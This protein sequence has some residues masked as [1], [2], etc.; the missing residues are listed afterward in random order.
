MRPA[1]SVGLARI[2]LIVCAMA[3]LWTAI[4]LP[5]G[6]Y[7]DLPQSRED[8]PEPPIKGVS[9]VR[10]CFAIEGLLLLWLAIRAPRKGVSSASVIQETPPLGSDLEHPVVWLTAIT[11]LALVLRIY[12]LDSDL[13]LDEI[14]TALNY[15]EMSPLHILTAYISS[16]NHLLNTL[17][18]K[19]SISAFGPSENAI[20]LPAVCFGVLGIPAQ[21]LLAR[22]ALHRRE[23][24]AAAFLLA[25]SYHHIFFSQNARGYTAFLLWA[26]L[27]TFFFLRL[28]SRHRRSDQ[29]FYVL[30]MFLCLASA[31]YGWFVFAGHVLVL[32]AVWLW[33]LRKRKSVIPWL[34]TPLASLA[35]LGLLGFHLNASIVPQVYAYVGHVYRTQATGYS[36][37]SLEL[38][39]ELNRGIA[40]GFGQS[41]LLAVAA[42]VV[43]VPA[44]F[45]C[46][47]KRPVYFLTLV[48]PLFVTGG[49]LIVK[50]LQVSPRFFAWG[51]PVTF[52]VVPM[53]AEGLGRSLAA[54]RLATIVP[55]RWVGQKG[56]LLLVTLAFC[57]LSAASLPSYYRTPKQPTR[58]S[59]QWVL[60]QMREGDVLATAYLA[61]WGLRFYGPS[62]ELEEGKSFHVTRSAEALKQV[63][64]ENVGKRIWLMSTFSR[65]LALDRPDLNQHIHDHYRP[66]RTF[67]A[68][69]G[70]GEIT[71]WVYARTVE[72][73]KVTPI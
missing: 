14:T 58:E 57:L 15:R 72:E 9:L 26:S 41:L 69:V 12:R 29:V 3:L 30:S 62:R 39:R 4:F 64:E 71:V 2:L 53:V 45:Y 51:L 73:E 21:Y 10:L 42:G 66:V 20:R 16:N 25:I 33:L 28:L 50:G 61:E 31:L 48:S 43:G 24:M 68:T 32:G 35:L 1:R 37:F 40:A 18:M 36:A 34:K 56:L 13:W 67:P 44:F 6:W 17:L 55:L 63:E 7:E 27:G 52:L 46:M 8:V 54:S 65:A 22:I 60:D 5:T 11:L 59:L 23:A 70:D 19:W 49:F 38:L 47:K